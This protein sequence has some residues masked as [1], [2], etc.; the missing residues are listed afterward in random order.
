MTL[1]SIS[2]IQ[3]KKRAPK[4]RALFRVD[5]FFTPDGQRRENDD[6]DTYGRPAMYP[7]DLMRVGEY[8]HVEA[9]PNRLSSVRVAVSTHGKRS[10]TRFTVSSSP[11]NASMV[12]VT[13]VS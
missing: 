6:V 7:F 5:H 11:S 3:P 1:T 12:T 2:L 10:G 9:A 4:K 8:F 13:R